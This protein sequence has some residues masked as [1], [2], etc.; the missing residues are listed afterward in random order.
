MANGMLA[1]SL[2]FDDSTLRPIGHPSC[3]ILPTLF[4]LGERESCTG[5]DLLEAYAVGL[6]VHARLGQLESGNWDAGGQWLPIGSIGQVGAA[7][8]AARLLDLHHGQVEN[9]LALA[10]HLAGQLSISIG[11]AAKAVGAGA[12]AWTAVQAADLARAGVDAP[13]RVIERPRGLADVFLGAGGQELGQLGQP[14]HLLEH[15]VAIKKYPAVYACQWPNDALRQLVEEHDINAGDLLR[16]EL[17]RPEAGAFCDCPRPGTVEEARSSFEYNLAAIA[18]TGHA[19][20]ASFTEELLQDP[21]QLAMQQRIAVTG[22][23]QGT[24]LS[25]TWRYLVRV[26]TRDHRIM[27]NWVRYPSGH[28]RNPLGAAEARAK[29]SACTDGHLSGDAVAELDR[30]LHDLEGQPTLGE[31]TGLLRTAR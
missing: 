12:A 27:E 20:L 19:G 3:T 24:P 28:P 9:C 26:H 11:T 6:E 21:A 22:H 7:A 1:H 23:P 16:I 30:L 8:A 2:E 31:I 10:A 5:R 13:G 15:G 18:L 25:H 17:L 14:H 29:F 4:A